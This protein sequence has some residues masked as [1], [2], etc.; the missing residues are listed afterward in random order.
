MRGC[1]RAAIWAVLGLLL[2]R[3]VLAEPSATAPA[4][5]QSTA[6]LDPASAAFAVRFARTYLSDPSAAA[7]APFL[8]EGV[9]A[10]GGTRPQSEAGA[11]AQAEVAG[12]EELGGGRSVLT[13]AAELRDARVLY[14]AVPIVRDRA[15][16][17]AA[18]GVP[19]IVAAPG[20][21]GAVSTERPQPLA[22][23][24]AAAIGELAD[25]FVPEYLA[26]REASSLAYLLAPGAAVVPL[27]GVLTLDAVTGVTQLGS[28][29]GPRR[30][31]L[32]SAR[33]GDPESG[34]TYPVAY[35]LEV[36]KAGGR[37]YVAGVQ[38]ASS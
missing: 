24:D 17:V 35:R 5:R 20:R 37:W 23:A 7:L 25:K 21:A 15:G 6:A 14:L 3:G 1:G 4:P 10:S 30:T 27:G 11:V 34:A 12:S 9:R 26:D 18:L 36:V 13:V 29:E 16:E 2:L 38:G 28:G 33:V 32:A 19:S 31:V 22:G 8:A